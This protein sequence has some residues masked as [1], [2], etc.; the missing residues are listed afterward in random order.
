M[1]ADRA[2]RP[3]CPW[4]GLYEG[5][6]TSLSDMAGRMQEAVSAHG[7][8]RVGVVTE[9][10]RAR[11]RAFS[12]AER[13]LGA[14]MRDV[15]DEVIVAHLVQFLHSIHGSDP[16]GVDELRNALVEAGVSLP[17]GD[18]PRAW[19]RAVRGAGLAAAAAAD[20]SADDQSGGAGNPGA[21]P[22]PPSAAPTTPSSPPPA[23]PP[24]SDDDVPPLWADEDAPPPATAP[25]D[26][27]A[28]PADSAQSTQ[29]SQ[30]AAGDAP[31]EGT[32]AAAAPR[33][34]AG[35]AT[36]D[37]AVSQPGQQPSGRDA[38]ASP[39][40][41]GT[42]DASPAPFDPDGPARH[43]ARYR[44]P[45]AS[46][47]ASLPQSSGKG[48]PAAPPAHPQGGAAAAPPPPA[49]PQPQGSPPGGAGAAGEPAGEAPTDAARERPPDREPVRPRLFEPPKSARKTTKRGGATRTPRVRA[50]PPEQERDRGADA[51]E[52]HERGGGGDGGNLDAA[53]RDRLFDLV[54][55]TRP[56]FHVDLAEA[57][58]DEDAVAAWVEEERDKGAQ[59][60]LRFITPKPRHRDLGPLV[61]PSKERRRDRDFARSLWGRCLDRYHGT[62]LFEVAALLRRFR[63]ERVFGGE[64]G[65][66]ALV[67]RVQ[68]PPRGM[69]GI[70]VA[71]TA[72]LREGGEARGEVAAA[73]EAL[74]AEPLSLVAALAPTERV[75]DPLVEALNDESARR[76]WAPAMPV[77]VA[78][79][80][81][82]A[83]DAS[84]SAVQVVT[85]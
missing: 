85:E 71:T 2:C 46:P 83:A 53:A 7:R 67:L 45:A 51:G 75:F 14:R 3:D 23:A 9:M 13:A 11:P 73:V 35:D 17:A 62:A 37:E 40:V 31:A 42:A 63:D 61:L 48:G 41:T 24:P 59:S 58:G 12:D 74:T 1:A 19:A 65:E 28:P 4:R 27:D 15:D 25:D 69:V 56:V 66:H 44:S 36:A 34:A 18:D 54:A 30:P 72:D 33:P 55:T 5:T 26:G 29:G 79:S 47:P 38:A 8:L 77:M 68:E 57:H 60:P 82:F 43:R 32:S 52:E 50:A 10:K 76:G 6:L 49:A 70:V 20:A 22:P 16:A 80:W 84:G 64:A 78:R 81:E 21:A 39:A